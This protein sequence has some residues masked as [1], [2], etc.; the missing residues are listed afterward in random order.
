MLQFT[1]EKFKQDHVPTIGVEYAAKSVSIDE[2]TQIKLQI[3]DTAGQ[4]A[5][6]AIVRT[7]YR[8]AAAVFL[9]YSITRRTTF[10]SL[11]S[12]LDES[13]DNCPE[14]TI[15]VLVGNQSDREERQ[16]THEEGMAFMKAHR[17]NLFFETSAKDGSCVQQ[18]FWE[19]G[20][21][22]FL[23]YV[24]ALG[25]TPNGPGRDS[26][27]KRLKDKTGQPYLNLSLIHI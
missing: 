13:R 9:V 5:F 25:R 24:K 15:Y 1:K 17:M 3:W 8:N 2:H 12:W 10:E 26:A 20:K 16:V 4:E 6:R 11:K 14:N 7:F 19:T 27:E 23:N 22:I 18:A 21:L